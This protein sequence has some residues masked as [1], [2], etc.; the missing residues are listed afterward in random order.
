MKLLIDVNLSQRW[1]AALAAVGYEAVHWRKVGL[2]TALDA[3]IMAYARAHG[4][5]VMTCDL[6]FGVLLALTGGTAP[7][8]VQVRAANTRLEVIFG[9]VVDG[10]QSSKEAL[11]A[12][13]LVSIDLLRARV[14]ML[15]LRA[16]D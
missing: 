2:A 11:E 14:R 7:S 1:V 10:L 15:P 12:G 8:V 6:D 9:Q 16:P 13:A 4:L 5:V 3:E